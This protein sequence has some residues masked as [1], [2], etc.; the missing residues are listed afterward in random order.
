[1]RKKKIK[2]LLPHPWKLVVCTRSKYLLALVQS[3]NTAVSNTLQS[4]GLQQA[5]LPCPSPTPRACSNSCPSSWWYHP[6]IS[7]SVAPFSSCL[8]SFPASGSFPM[9]QLFASGSQRVGA[10]I[11]HQS[12]Q[13]IFMTN[14]QMFKLVLEKAEEPEMK[15]PTPTGS[16]KK[17]ESSRKTSISDLL[18]MPKPLNSVDHNKLWKIL[19]EMRIPDHLTCLLRNLYAGKEASVRTGQGTTDWFQIGR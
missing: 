17:Q 9:S 19:E 16:S 15:L 5:R 12:F 2:G 13:W 8:Q 7:S 18:T 4:H 14:F 11:Q 10:S 1:M 3:N 6:T